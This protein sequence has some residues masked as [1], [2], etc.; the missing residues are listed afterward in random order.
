MNVEFGNDLM[1]WEIRRVG[2]GRLTM[3]TMVVGRQEML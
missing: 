1:V 3:Y 2:M